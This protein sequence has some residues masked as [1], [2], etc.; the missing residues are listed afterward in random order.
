VGAERAAVARG[1]DQGR[2]HE[3][4]YGQDAPEEEAA[5]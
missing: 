1:G 3:G 5:F 2:Q 4:R